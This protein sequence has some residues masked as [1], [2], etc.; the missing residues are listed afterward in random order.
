MEKCQNYNLFVWRWHGVAGS[1]YRNSRLLKKLA[2]YLRL[3]A[4][5]VLCQPLPS[6]VLVLFLA[7]DIIETVLK[8]LFVFVLQSFRYSR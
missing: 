6:A 5:A 1:V 4:P 3:A 8:L 2:V 7:K